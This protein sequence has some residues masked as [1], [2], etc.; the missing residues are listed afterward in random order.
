MKR[1]TLS[2]MLA[3][4]AGGAA[5]GFGL[6]PEAAARQRAPFRPSASAASSSSSSTA[7]AAAG[8]R[9]G[10]LRAAAGGI[11]GLGAAASL[12]CLGP[13]PA[14]AV[15]AVPKVTVDEFLE[16]ARVSA[17]SV[18]VV[19]FSGPK[20][21]LALAKLVDGTYF[22]VTGLV[23]SPSDPRSPLKLAASCRSLGVPTRFLDL[24]LAVGGAGNKRK[25]VYANARVQEAARKEREKAERIAEDEG[26][27]LTELREI[28]AREMATAAAAAEEATAAAAADG[29]AP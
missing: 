11:G 5:A 29:G 12:L 8:G 21:E 13:S 7:L 25:K 1:G 18:A 28:E 22:Q 24:E 23:E 16:I 6:A 19:E 9:R 20:S 27:R 3:L 10:F 15:T 26:L 14:L 4:Q 2:A 17:K